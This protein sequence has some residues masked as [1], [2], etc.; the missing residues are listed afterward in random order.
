MLKTAE[1]RGDKDCRT[2][3]QGDSKAITIPHPVP[4]IYYSSSFILSTFAIV[5]V[6]YMG[7]NFE[8]TL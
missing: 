8:L 3:L 2:A 4:T 7:F 1:K 5:N 6:K